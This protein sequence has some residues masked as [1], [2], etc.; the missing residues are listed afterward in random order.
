METFARLKDVLSQTDFKLSETRLAD[1]QDNYNEEQFK[2]LIA[3]KASSA[4]IQVDRRALEAI[5]P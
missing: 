5:Q 3:S 4:V 1:V 2:K